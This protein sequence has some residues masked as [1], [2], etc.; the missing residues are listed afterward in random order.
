MSACCSPTSGAAGKQPTEQQCEAAL[1]P[2]PR[3]DPKNLRI[4][5]PVAAGVF[6]GEGRLA[7]AAHRRQHPHPPLNQNGNRRRVQFLVN[8]QEIVVP[9]GEE[10]V[11]GIGQIDDA[12]HLLR[13][14]F[15]ELGADR[16]EKRLRDRLIWRQRIQRHGVPA[17][18]RR[19]HYVDCL[20]FGQHRKHGRVGIGLVARPF[21]L[22]PSGGDQR[23][24][25]AGSLAARLDLL[26]P[27]AAGRQASL[28]KPD[29][30]PLRCPSL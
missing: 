29:A 10:R 16:G 1:Q 5:A 23:Q 21:R 9:P 19:G 26:V 6:V 8:A 4:E 3:V 27:V 15:S 24:D 11:G 13:R 25:H 14:R 28:V 17:A 2:G 30:E 18:Q 20:A 12:G 22:R 7:D